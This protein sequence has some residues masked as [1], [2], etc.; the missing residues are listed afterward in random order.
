MN[1]TSY[2]HLVFNSNPWFS[3]VSDYS[4]QMC[5]YLKQQDDAVLY[6]ADKNHSKMQSHCESHTI[7][8]R[9]VPI[10]QVHVFAFV[11]SLFRMIYL[12]SQNKKTLK[13]V[14]CFEGR[15]H[16]LLF[17]IKLFF[18]FLLEKVQFIRVRGQAQPIK[19]NFFSKILYRYFTVKVVF[20]AQCIQK[21][22]PFRLFASRSCV[23]YYGKNLHVTQNTDAIY[24]FHSE[25]E[26]ANFNKLTFLMLGRFDPVKGHQVLLEAYFNA[27]LQTSSQL[28]FI[29]KSENIKVFDFYHTWAKQF[30]ICKHMG[31]R[32]MLQ[33]QDGKKTIYF[34]DEFFIDTHVLLPKVHFGV[35]PSLGSEVICRVGVEF[36]QSGVP[37]VFSDAGALSEVLEDFHEFLFPVN[38]ASALQTK[39]ERA[40]NCFLDTQIFQGLREKAFSIGKNKYSLNNFAA[41]FSALPENR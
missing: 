37:V 7:P 19:A 9:H 14:V 28:I 36:L 15:E 11:V 17:L 41:I 32:Y 39:L 12:L 40:E 4:L 6:C 29:G 3:A 31:N 27:Q 25:F 16:F 23:V 26:P 13:S 24:S 33:T 8:F 35:I 20:A 2:Q 34:V 21:Q 1:K 18:P 30:P 5:L 10:H 38:N 22:L